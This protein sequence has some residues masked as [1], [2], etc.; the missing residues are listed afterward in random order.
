MTKTFLYEWRFPSGNRLVNTSWASCEC[1]LRLKQKPTQKQKGK[2]LAM[3]RLLVSLDS[4]A[5]CSHSI[6][7]QRV[8]LTGKHRASAN[9]SAY[10]LSSV[11]QFFQRSPPPAFRAPPLLAI[12]P[13]VLS[14]ARLDTG[15]NPLPSLPRSCLKPVGGLFT[16]ALR[17]ALAHAPARCRRSACSYPACPPLSDKIWISASEEPTHT[18]TPRSSNVTPKP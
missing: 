3:R 15:A 18:H 1:E 12:I 5:W 11:A 10:T 16:A 17:V 8:V 13:R 7:Q 9:I 2:T 14:P 4:I 6:A